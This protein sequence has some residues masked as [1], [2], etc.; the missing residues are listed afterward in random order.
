LPYQPTRLELNQSLFAS[1]N[2]KVG[3]TQTVNVR[4]EG[5][6][7]H[8][9]TYRAALNELPAFLLPG[10]FPIWERNP[11]GE[12]TLCMLSPELITKYR[13]LVSSEGNR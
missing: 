1:A 6:H 2:I 7:G 4:F 5:L 12:D 10:W 8:L 3:M 11:T 9:K 13:T